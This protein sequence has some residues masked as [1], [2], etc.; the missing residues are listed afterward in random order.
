MISLA[1]GT[2]DRRAGRSQGQTH[3]AIGLG[4]AL[5]TLGL[6]LF[7]AIASVTY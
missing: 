7:F 6:A 5:V 3:A 4:I 2:A 1:K